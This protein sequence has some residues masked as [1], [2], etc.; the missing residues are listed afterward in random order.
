MFYRHLVFISRHFSPRVSSISMFEHVCM[1][2]RVNR[3]ANSKSL[4][5]GSSRFNSRELI[6]AVSANHSFGNLRLIFRD[7][8]SARGGSRAS[9]N[10][11]FE[12]INGR[13]LLRD[14]LR[15]IFASFFLSFSLHARASSRDDSRDSRKPLH[16]LM[17]PVCRLKFAR[18]AEGWQSRVQIRTAILSP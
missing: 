17:R 8:T 4:V 7:M 2:A 15:A 12:T 18:S 11:R 6:F 5:H 9:P 1:Y 10:D 13:F 14:C 3:P 16:I